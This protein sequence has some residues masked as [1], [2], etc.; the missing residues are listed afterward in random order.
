MELSRKKYKF[1]KFKKKLQRNKL[2]LIFNVVANDKWIYIN[3]IFKNL[4]IKLL[5]ISNKISQL[6][7]KN[8]IYSNYKYILNNFTMIAVMPSNSS[9][10]LKELNTIDE[11]I[12]LLGIR[13]N[14][15]LYLTRQLQKVVTTHYI[16]S[17]KR[18][19]KKLKFCVKIFS[20]KLSK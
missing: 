12:Y 5:K 16:K 11:N 6:I 1:S 8:S 9:L 18:L 2:L 13:L 3:Q 17:M 19:I 4:N 7:F 14:K 10:K 15:N 20:I